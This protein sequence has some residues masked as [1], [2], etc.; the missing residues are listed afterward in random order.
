MRRRVIGIMIFNHEIIIQAIAK[1]KDIEYALDDLY[2][3]MKII[4]NHLIENGTLERYSQ[5]EDVLKAIERAKDESNKHIKKL[6]KIAWLYD[7]FDRETA[8]LADNLPD[9]VS[10]NMISDW[11]STIVI[12][13][14]EKIKNEVN[15]ILSN[16][17]LQHEEWL[18]NRMIEILGTDKY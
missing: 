12:H 15:P 7:E 8:K 13:G 16:N 10:N 4:I 17:L 11:I 9:F 3:K 14:I 6:Q 18:I 5:L 1:L 2:Q